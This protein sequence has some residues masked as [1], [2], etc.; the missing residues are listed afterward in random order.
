MHY[1]F[2][3]LRRYAEFRGRSRRTEYW[4]FWVLQMILSF[5]PGLVGALILGT[6]FA[7]EGEPGEAAMMGLGAIG[8]LQLLIGLLLIVPTFSV[9]VRRLHD[10]NRSG[11]WILAPLPFVALAIMLAFTE[12]GEGLSALMMFLMLLGFLV[13]SVMLFVFMLLDGTRGP[14][15]YGP[16][17]KAP[18]HREI[19]A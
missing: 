15:R 18:D 7:Y 8:L 11:W 5:V 17:P 19:F 6:S 12:L 13:T 9:T 10:T 3:P 4:L 1:M 14:N 2:L 16:D